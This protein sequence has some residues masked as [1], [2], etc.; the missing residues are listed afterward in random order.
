MIES[1]EIPQI[2][3]VPPVYFLMW[4]VAGFALNS[5]LPTITLAGP[6]ATAA[7][8]LL[9]VT[10]L[11]INQWSVRAFKA[12]QTPLYV[13]RPAAVMVTAG[14]YQYTRNPLYLSMALCMVA[15]ALVADQLWLLLTAPLF[16]MVF[17]QRVIIPEERYLEMRFGHEYIVYKQAVA[18]W[19]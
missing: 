5:L 12:A 10:A 1:S 16:F 17:N 6:P 14:P 11:G 2:R 15:F 7:G 18:R 4:L 13:R 8:I 19:V 3:W 9:A